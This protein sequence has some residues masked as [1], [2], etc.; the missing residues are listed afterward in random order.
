MKKLLVIL[1]ALGLVGISTAAVAQIQPAGPV[2]SVC[3][4][5]VLRVSCDLI[6][7]TPGCYPFDFETGSGGVRQQ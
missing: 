6:G 3:S 7:Q 4:T 5:Q 2:A 1:I